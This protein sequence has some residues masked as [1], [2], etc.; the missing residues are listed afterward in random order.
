MLRVSG[1]QFHNLYLVRLSVLRLLQRGRD[2]SE[3]C[4]LLPWSLSFGLDKLLIWCRFRGSVVCVPMNFF[5]ISSSSATFLCRLL[6]SAWSED[7]RILFL[8]KKKKT[9]KW[10]NKRGTY[11]PNGGR[12]NTRYHLPLTSHFVLWASDLF[13]VIVPVSF[14]QWKYLL[15]SYS[16][17]ECICRIMASTNRQYLAVLIRMCITFVNSLVI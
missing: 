10:S 13:P 11:F 16:L 6:L 8:K 12:Y 3:W 5:T 7:K 15:L 17:L 4:C 2:F 14:A 1:H 9:K